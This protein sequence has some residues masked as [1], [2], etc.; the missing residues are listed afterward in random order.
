MEAARTER[1][2]LRRLALALAIASSLALTAYPPLAAGSDGRAAHGALTLLLWGIAAGFV[3][4][5]GFV[6]RS[7]LLRMALGPHAALSLM[8]VGALLL[9]GVFSR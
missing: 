3:A 8:A 1:G 9:A 7:R 4:G 6:P 5:V 2:A